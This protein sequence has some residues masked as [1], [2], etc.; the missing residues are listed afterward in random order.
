[1][2][3]WTVFYT[4]LSGT[5]VFVFGQIILQF[6]IVPVQEFLKTIAAIAHA[7]VEDAQ[8]TSNPGVLSAERMEETSRHLRRLSAQLHSHLFLVRPYVPVS[9]IFGLPSRDHVLQASRSLIGLSNSVFSAN[10]KTYESNAGKWEK[11]CDTLGIG[12]EPDDRWPKE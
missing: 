11:I 3:V 7:R 6:V 10:E 12:I 1:M 8:V 9:R 2:N 5:F 4:V